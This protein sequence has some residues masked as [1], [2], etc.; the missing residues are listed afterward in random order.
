MSPP[1][2]LLYFHY[3]LRVTTAMRFNQDAVIHVGTPPPGYNEGWVTRKVHWHAFSSLSAVRGEFVES[4]EF[5][6]L[7][8][9][10]RVQLYPGGR[11]NSEEGKVSLGLHNMSNKAIEI[12]FGFSVNN[13]NLKQVEYERSPG[14]C[15]FRPV[16]GNGWSDFAYR[17]YLLY[18]LVDGALV[19]QVHM[20]LATPTISVPPP[21][22]P[23]NPVA[24]MIQGLLLNEKSADI[25]FEVVGENK[26]KDNAMK[27]A[28][29]APITFPAHR[30]SIVA[31]CSSILAEIMCESNGDDRT[32]TIQ[33]TDVTPDAFRYILFYMYGGKISD[34]DMKSHA[35]EIIDA[36]DK[37]G[38]TSLK[39]EAE[40]SIVEDT[41]ITMDNVME[42]LLYILT[43]RT[44][45]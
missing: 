34:S 39:L 29:T 43:P 15:N 25:V 12:D 9:Q 13:D 7:G 37:F 45:L 38:I 6:G 4:P 19:I 42:L 36:A 3:Y 1:D 33:I 26:S 5:E 30:L 40:A 2:L 20:K 23:E 44:V 31:N 10:W 16:D 22:I 17:S 18:F 41:T 21:F 24:K 11:R 14:P 8:N 28:N 27:M 32:N 35:K